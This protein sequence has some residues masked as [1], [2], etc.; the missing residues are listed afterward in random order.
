MKKQLKQK[1]KQIADN[2]LILLLLIYIVL[3]GN[4][5]FS[6]FKMQN[7]YKI[8]F[9]RSIAVFNFLCFYNKHT[10]TVSKSLTTYIKEFFSANFTVSESNGCKSQENHVNCTKAKF[11]FIKK[12][13]NMFCGVIYFFHLSQC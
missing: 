3:G 9:Q 12:Q 4:L 2:L 6:C 8:Q 7:V 5:V 10:P 11:N 1:Q 13:K